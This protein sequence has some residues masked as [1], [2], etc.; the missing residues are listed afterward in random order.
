MTKKL[1]KIL[2]SMLNSNYDYYFEDNL[3]IGTPPRCGKTAF[4]QTLN[5][6]DEI[7]EGSLKRGMKINA[8]MQKK[9]RIG[10]SDFMK[11]YAEIIHE[12]HNLIQEELMLMEDWS[13]QEANQWIDANIDFNHVKKHTINGQDYLSIDPK[14]G[15]KYETR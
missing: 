3:L 7:I 9:I 8:L 6:K 12:M 5:C 10:T 4:Q 11:K 1:D 15:D 13:E 2:D 14:I